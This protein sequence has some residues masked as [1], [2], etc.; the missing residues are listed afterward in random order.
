M[1]FFNDGDLRIKK[2]N[3]KSS[4]I[5]WQVE[6]PNSPC[7]LSAEQ[8]HFSA[9]HWTLANH[10]WKV[11]HGLG[12]SHHFI[13]VKGTFVSI[14]VNTWLRLDLSDCDLNFQ[15]NIQTSVKFLPLIEYPLSQI[16]FR[17]HVI[18]FSCPIFSQLFFALVFACMSVFHTGS[19]HSAAWCLCCPLCADKVPPCGA[20]M[21]GCKTS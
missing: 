9:P 7:P 4:A 6:I 11:R 1:F 14:I 17:S 20:V 21:N 15:T 13:E 10:C 18:I 16:Q 19:I 3:K 12:S 2:P 8:H 5:R